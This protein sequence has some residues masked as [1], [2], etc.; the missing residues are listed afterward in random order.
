MHIAAGVVTCLAG[1]GL[2]VAAAPLAHADD[3]DVIREARSIGILN[4]DVNIIS[5]GRS[6]CY[7]LRLG[8]R[9]PVEISG[10][11]ARTFVIDQD[12][13][14]RFSLASANEWCPQWSGLFAD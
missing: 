10:K 14:R 1:M 6:V 12:Q 9:P 7:V 8:N 4:S 3:A 13:A 11:I 5:A 2:V